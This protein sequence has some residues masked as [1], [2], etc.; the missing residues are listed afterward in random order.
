MNKELVAKAFEVK[1][2]YEEA[3]AQMT[4]L[5]MVNELKDYRPEHEHWTGMQEIKFIRDFFGL[6]TMSEYEMQNL[7]DMVVMMFDSWMDNA[8]DSDE[9]WSLSAGMM[10]ITAVIDDMMFNRF[11][12]ERLV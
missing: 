12:R 8:K 6:Y 5:Q 10:S 1:K 2:M 3:G 9:R 7:R 11:T 4:Y